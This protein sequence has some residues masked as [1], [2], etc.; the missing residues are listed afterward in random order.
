[1]LAKRDR[2]LRRA[3][4][5]RLSA[6]S[7]EDLHRARILSKQVRYAGEFFAPLWRRKATRPFLEVLADLQ[8]I[9]GQLNDIA[10]A[11]TRLT[12]GHEDGGRAWAAGLIAGWHA[13]RRPHLLAQAEKA[14]ARYRKA[15]RFWTHG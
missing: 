6:L 13:G 15:E 14:W 3:G 7:T 1:V 8:D 11:R 5:D 10:V 2:R 9:L 4:G 12:S